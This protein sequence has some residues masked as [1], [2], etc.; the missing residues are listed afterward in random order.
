MAGHSNGEEPSR[1]EWQSKGM[2]EMR[3]ELQRLRGDEKG[4]DARRKDTQRLRLER[5]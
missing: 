3:G 1:R 5:Q 2:E 4:G